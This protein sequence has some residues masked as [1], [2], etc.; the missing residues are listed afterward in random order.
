[1]PKFF[2][3]KKF[4]EYIIPFSGLKQGE[5]QFDYCIKKDFIQRFENED[6]L[7]SDINLLVNL[8]KS[9]R[10]LHFHFQ[11]QG[12]VT[13]ECD[14]CLDPIDLPMNSNTKLIVK[15]EDIDEFEDDIVYLK[16]DESEFDISGFVY[17]SILFAIPPRNVH[18]EGKCN[19][20][21]IEKL[22]KLLVKN[23]D[24]ADPRWNELKNLLN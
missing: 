10:I 24:P 19:P 6:L 5:H 11:F 13:V 4:T 14:R 9:H 12:T 16:P 7:D 2:L 18:D 15:L 23:Q 20:E 3:V 21:M 17:E 22:E 8:V 1:L